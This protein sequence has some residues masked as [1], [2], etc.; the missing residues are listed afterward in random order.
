MLTHGGRQRSGTISLTAWLILGGVAWCVASVG[1]AIV[2][3]RTVAQRER[4]RPRDPSVDLPTRQGVEIQVPAARQSSGQSL[5][6]R[7][8]RRR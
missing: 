8:L 2:I 4:Q 6:S 1:L 5:A 7:L 3:G